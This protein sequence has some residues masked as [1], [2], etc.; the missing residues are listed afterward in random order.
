MFIEEKMMTPAQIEKAAQILKKARLE[1]TVIDQIPVEIRPQNLTEAYA[2]QDRLI[3]ILGLETAGWFCACTN[4]RIQEILQLR[5]PYYARLLKDYVLIQPV[6]LNSTDYPPIVIECEFGFRLARDLPRRSAIYERAEIEDAILEVHPTI[7]VVAGHL[8]D[9]PNQDVWSVIADNGTDGA[10]IVGAGNRNWRDIAL[11][12]VFVTLTVNG[13]RVRSGYGNNILGD[14]VVALVWLAN[15]R[16]R[17]GDGLKAGHIHNT[18]TAT[19]IYWASPGDDII[20]DFK[21]LGSVSLA[22]RD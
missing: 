3:E 14:P 19:D 13:R 7:E 21:G 8:R 4:K 22:L 1:K 20:A 6:T 15:A 11:E 17:D 10:L 12:Q 16:S 9:W 5:E 2:I 18:G